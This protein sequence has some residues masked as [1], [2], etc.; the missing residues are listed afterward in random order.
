MLYWRWGELQ[1]AYLFSWLLAAEARLQ[2]VI[3]IKFTHLE[4]ADCFCT[5]D[6]SEKY[7]WHCFDFDKYIFAAFKESKVV[8]I[9]RLF[10]DPEQFLPVTQ[11]NLCILHQIPNIFPSHF[12]F[13]NTSDPELF[14]LA[15]PTIS[16]FFFF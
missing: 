11:M 4:D 8:I 12:L 2:S 13:K 1:A 15:S 7:L 10:L 6:L 3:A 16:F 5:P 14:L 9:Q